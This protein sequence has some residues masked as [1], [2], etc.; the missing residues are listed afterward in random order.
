[1]PGDTMHR[2]M[3]DWLQLTPELLSGLPA[4]ALA[5]AN[6][7]P[8]PRSAPGG[9]EAVASISAG[10]VLAATAMRF[11]DVGCAQRPGCVEGAGAGRL[12][13]YPEDIFPVALGT[14]NPIERGGNQRAALAEMTSYLQTRLAP[15]VG[16]G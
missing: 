6:R 11:E 7:A 16:E 15:G 8:A 1:M 14:Y 2:S 5:G 3:E 13:A 12:L 4:R 9:G 10:K